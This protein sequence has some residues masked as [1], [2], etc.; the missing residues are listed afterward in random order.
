M[1]TKSKIKLYIWLAAG[2][3]ICFAGALMRT[4]KATSFDSF[5]QVGEI[6]DFNKA[7]L[8]L[9]TS[10]CEYSEQTG[11]FTVCNNDAYKEF[12]KLSS[13]KKWSY[14]KI[15]I[16]KLNVTN[17]EWIICYMNKN[18]EVLMEQV[19]TIHPGENL[20][21]IAYT[22]K[23]SNIQIRIKN[24]AGAMF[25]I[26]SMQLRETN[27]EVT[28]TEVLM[29]FIKNIIVYALLSFL[30]FM[31]LRGQCYTPV[32]VIQYAYLLTGNYWGSKIYN[33]FSER[34]RNRLRVFFFWLLFLLNIAWQVRG[35]Y[36]NET[37]YKYNILF[38]CLLLILIGL[39]TWEKPLHELNWKHVL[40]AAWFVLWFGVCVSDLF[41]S[42]IIKFSGY[43][44]L[45]GV[46]F[47]FFL[48]SQSKK[49]GKVLRN[50]IQGLEWTLPVVVLYCVIFRQKQSNVIYNGCFQNRQDMSF[51]VLA[52]FIV[53]LAELHSVLHT[54]HAE[55]IFRRL[56]VYGVG[57]LFAVYFLYRSWTPL[58]LAAAA[59]VLLIWLVFQWHQRGTLCFGIGQSI[60]RL[61][62]V[63]LIGTLLIIPVDIGI[64]KI[65]KY[66]GTSIKYTNEV[67][68]TKLSETE[69][70]KSREKNSK[71]LKGVTSIEQQ[72]KVLIWKNYFRELNLLGNDGKL[73]VAR[74]ET[75]SYNGFLEMA[76][77]YG[78]FVLIPYVLLL[79]LCL[80]KAW[81]EKKFL[82]L[83]V[84]ISYVIL[85]F[86]ENVEFPF[87]NSLWVIFYLGMGLWFGRKQMD[88]EEADDVNDDRA[89]LQ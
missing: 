49:P 2:L 8:K 80:R 61:F 36:Y 31:I 54:T 86:G 4:T 52:L 62:A 83:A 53:F 63:I 18:K 6:Y 5:F 42:K 24:Q 72:D 35:W 51:Y 16:R 1:E 65:P 28:V 23:F 79:F 66:L 20:I 29:E 3:L 27:T 41:V 34:H 81:K 89:L 60:L 30:V 68:E 69:L 82:M 78:L 19:C 74:V 55:K 17:T 10:S 64:S 44:M 26:Q 43:A 57:T 7:D 76:Y 12:H 25:H 58:C 14:L 73:K 77:R 47:C 88:L 37:F 67:R 70:E 59:V 22:D 21:P 56:A 13:N 50:M 15:N 38:H 48:W 87:A 75:S 9:D 84:S 71:F 11:L 46:G 40:P 32:S 39:L 85:L 45:F 33:R